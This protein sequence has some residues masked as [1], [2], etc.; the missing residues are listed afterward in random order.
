MKACGLSPLSIIGRLLA[1]K[2]PTAKHCRLW[3]LIVLVLSR[4]TSTT[5]VLWEC[6]GGTQ[7]FW[8]S[9][10]IRHIHRQTQLRVPHQNED[11]DTTGSLCSCLPKSEI[12]VFEVIEV[13]EGYFGGVEGGMVQVSPYTPHRPL[14]VRRAPCYSF[15]W[16]ESLQEC[17]PAFTE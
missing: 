7:P 5:R 14:L 8:W 9:T 4:A 13:I 16:S 15:E 17:R 6:E 10:L 12:E 11:A 1:A 2:R 3:W